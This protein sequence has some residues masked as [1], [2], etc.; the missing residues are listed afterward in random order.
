[1]ILVRDIRLP[2]SAGEPQAFEKALHLAR[3]PRSKAAHLGV[4]RLSVDARHGQPKLVYTIAVTLKDEGEESAYAG[5]SPC[6]AIRGKT[7]LSVQNGT[8]RLPHR[9]VVCGLGP[10]GLFAALLLARQGYKPIVLERGPAL[11]ERVKA[12]EHFSATGELD[13][14]AN[15]QFGE[16]GAGTF[17]DGKLTPRIGDA[18]CGFVAEECLPH[19]AP[20]DE[21]AVQLFERLRAIGFHTC[22]LSNNKAAR[23]APFAGQ[24]GS[25]Y[26]YKGRKPKR[27]GYRQ[28]LRRMG[29]GERSTMCVGDQLFTDVYGARRTGIYSILVKPINPKEEIQIVLKRYLE[30]IV[31]WFYVRRQEKK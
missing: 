20:A 6:V 19:G 18:L 3:I 25:D 13:P 24:V 5:A 2:L 8:Q 7:D 31:L 29:T 26:I 14:N 12:V 17:S 27:S 28:A 23:V 15:I 10:A 30:K 22:L 16:G 9:P 11:D 21:R 4:A 1:M